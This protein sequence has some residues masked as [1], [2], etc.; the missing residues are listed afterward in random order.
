[1]AIK[2]ET[3][4]RKS[5]KADIKLTNKHTGQKHHFGIEITGKCGKDK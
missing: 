2:K 5:I 3:P 4:K 1:M